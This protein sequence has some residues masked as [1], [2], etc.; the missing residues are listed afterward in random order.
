MRHK[1]R[2]LA[3]WCTDTILLIFNIVHKIYFNFK[4][5]LGLLHDDDAVLNTE[6]VNVAVS[7]NCLAQGN[8][9]CIADDSNDD[10]GSVTTCA[11]S[12]GLAFLA[13]L[14]L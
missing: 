9:I 2:I 10:S 1:I 3:Q 5:K 4:F 11:A 14:N 8:G 6:A 7:A 12:T 13:L